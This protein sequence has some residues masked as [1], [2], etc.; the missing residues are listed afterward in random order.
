MINWQNKY[1]KNIGIN[2]FD[3]IKYAV[4]DLKASLKNLYRWFPL[5]WKDRDWDDYYIWV[6]L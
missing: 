3:K 4:R 2:I 5:I 1:L 6:L